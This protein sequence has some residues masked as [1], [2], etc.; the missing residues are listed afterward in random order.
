MI[1]FFKSIKLFI[2]VKNYSDLI[3]LKINTI[4]VGDL[5]TDSII[6]FRESKLPTVKTSSISTIIYYYR[7]FQ[8]LKFYK[9][10]AHNFNIKKAFI[11]QSVFIEHG[12]PLRQFFNEKVKV[13]TSA[14][15]DMC[16]FKEIK[17]KNDTG[18]PYSSKYKQIF[19]KKFSQKEIDIGLKNFSSRFKG[20]D[21]LGWFDNFGD[22]PYKKVDITSEFNFDGVLFLHDFYDGPHFYGKTIFFD[23]YHWALNTLEFIAKNNLKVAIKTHPFQSER[24]NEVCNYLKERFNYLVW[25]DMTSNKFLFDKG[26]KFGITQHGTV[27][28][29]L[30]YH[31][32][33]PIYCG[34]HPADYFDIGFKA[35]SIK[36]YEDYILNF[37][38]LKFKKNLYDEI[39][40]Y[41]YMHHMYD[42][43]DYFLEK[44]DGYK[45]KGIKNRFFYDTS[46]LELIYK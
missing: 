2:K 24:S 39:G 30:A 44:S 25:I 9:K 28:S 41:Y 8:Y 3:K 13:Y 27:I 33:K 14:S 42:K 18:I 26:I 1:V 36:Q 11:S 22:H 16:L 5:I 17:E 23:F 46:D 32:I 21:D 19:H 45:I 10:T 35:N 37:N 20:I 31:K 40:K 15:L 29:E 4:L 7:A 34:D 43:S 6:R 12:I 38:N